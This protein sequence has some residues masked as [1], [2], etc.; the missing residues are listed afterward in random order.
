MEQPRYVP[1]LCWKCENTHADKC[2]WFN[3]DNPEP[4]KG[5]SAI[6]RDVLTITTSHGKP[7]SRAEVSYCVLDCPNFKAVK[8]RRKKASLSVRAEEG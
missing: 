4:V 1:T 2:S 3:K 6:R 5:W 7:R 8:K